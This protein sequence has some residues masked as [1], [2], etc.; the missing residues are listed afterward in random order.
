MSK[1]NVKVT[2]TPDNTVVNVAERHIKVVSVGTQGVP[3][4]HILH[5]AVDA[6]LADRQDG[7]VMEFSEQTQK[8]EAT[9]ELRNIK[10]NCGSF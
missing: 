9:N 10:I 2:V 7:S 3:G 5:G 6:N 1:V 8:W 4:P